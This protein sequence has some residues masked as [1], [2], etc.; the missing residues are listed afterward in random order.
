MFSAWVTAYTVDMTS[1]LLFG[2]L[3][4]VVGARAVT[5]GLNTSKGQIEMSL[6]LDTTIECIREQCPSVI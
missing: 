2:D 3:K 4:V 6:V 5:D 1:S